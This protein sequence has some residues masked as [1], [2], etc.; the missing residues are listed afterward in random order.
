[1][2][3][4]L[5]RNI[6]KKTD[7]EIFNMGGEGENLCRLTLFGSI[8]KVRGEHGVVSSAEGVGEV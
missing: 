3:Y 1:M 5:G 7:P 2:T 6:W 4:V 8:E